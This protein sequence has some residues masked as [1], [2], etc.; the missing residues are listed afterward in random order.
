[1][2][3]R[4]DPENAEHPPEPDEQAIVES[5]TDAPDEIDLTV[6][7]I[8]TTVSD[9]QRALDELEGKLA[10]LRELQRSLAKVD[11]AGSSDAPPTQKR[12][13]SVDTLDLRTLMTLGDEADDDEFGRRFREFANADPDESTRAWLER[14]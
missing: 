7:A 8:R 10:G 9:D 2:T 14:G 1:M 11:L 12:E 3:G 6:E 13:G 5:S 4:L